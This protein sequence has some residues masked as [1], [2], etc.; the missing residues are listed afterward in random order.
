MELIGAAA[1]AAAVGVFGISREKK[2]VV[3]RSPEKGYGFE[4]YWDG[5]DESEV[6]EEFVWSRDEGLRK[7]MEAISGFGYSDFR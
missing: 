6:S 2:T 7:E 3:T 4:E 5:E 1:S